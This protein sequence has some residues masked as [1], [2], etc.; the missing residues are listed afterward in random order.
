MAKRVKIPRRCFS[1]R[2]FPSVA[3]VLLWAVLPQLVFVAP[4]LSGHQLCHQQPLCGHGFGTSYRMC[5]WRCPAMTPDRPDKFQPRA[6]ITSRNRSEDGEVLPGTKDALE[7][8]AAPAAPAPAPA[9]RAMAVSKDPE[10]LDIL[11]NAPRRADARAKS[12]ELLRCLSHEAS[13]SNASNGGAEGIG[14]SC[15]DALD[16]TQSL[17]KGSLQLPRDLGF[18]LMNL[19]AALII[20][21][22]GDQ[23]G[24]LS[25]DEFIE[26]AAV[27]VQLSDAQDS[28]GYR[29]PT[30]NLFLNLTSELLAKPTLLAILRLLGRILREISDSVD[31]LSADIRYSCKI[32]AK[33]LSLMLGDD[34]ENAVPLESYEWALLSRAASDA[35]TLVPFTGICALPLPLAGQVCLFWL[36]KTAAPKL[37]PSS[38]SPLRLQ[39]AQARRDVRKHPD[40]KDW[41]LYGQASEELDAALDENHNGSVSHSTVLSIVQAFWGGQL[42]LPKHSMEDF[43]MDASALM[44]V[45]DRRRTGALTLGEFTEFLQTLVEVARTY[46]SPSRPRGLFSDDADDM[47]QSFNLNDMSD[48]LFTFLRD[49]RYGIYVLKKSLKGKLTLLEQAMLKRTA[50]DVLSILPYVVLARS[51]LTPA[52]KIFSFMLLW[53]SVPVLS[54]SASTEPRQRFARAWASIAVK[55]RHRAIAGWQLLEQ[56]ASSGGTLI[57]DIKKAK[58]STLQR[59]RVK[60]LFA[61]HDEGS[62]T[63]TYGQVFS[64]LQPFMTRQGDYLNELGLIIQIASDND[65][66]VTEAEFSE[67]VESLLIAGKAWAAPTKKAIEPRQN[68]TDEKSTGVTRVS[69]N[70][71]LLKRLKNF[72][73]AVV[74]RVKREVRELVD[75]VSMISQ[76]FSYSAALLRSPREVAARETERRAERRFSKIESA[77]LWRTLKDV[78]LFLPIAAIIIAPLT[79]VGTAIVIA[80][81]KRA[82]PSLVPS[83]FRR[84]RLELM[85]ARRDRTA[86]QI[87]DSGEESAG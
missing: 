27:M 67:F 13:A 81:F 43:R 41:T 11:R 24:V 22:D 34:L 9:T 51:A 38:F 40:F 84:P 19:G 15:Q 47:T 35:V 31:M 49:L 18:D 87:S 1:G 64:I 79:P 68:S 78:V 28:P 56:G 60:E 63:L 12:A 45:V 53:K 48:S 23:D 26:Y 50:R 2:R 3:S 5:K 6:Y 8:P 32:L 70:S 57:D 72:R 25:L 66:A 33:R 75:S 65:G 14:I 58:D 59:Q 10:L 16:F 37:L 71:A 62:G 30:L 42:N 85:S 44:V 74:K 61:E 80:I 36:I 46:D 55:Q 77:W 54:P 4:W 17:W 52:L 29:D 7:N 20:S 21:L 83:S 73:V 82:V 39:L 86:T 69:W 76:D